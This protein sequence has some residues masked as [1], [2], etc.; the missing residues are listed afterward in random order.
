MVVG[1]LSASLGV[2]HGGKSSASLGVYHG[3]KRA[4]QPPRVIPMV[5]RGSQPPRV[6]PVS[7]LVESSH[8]VG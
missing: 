1:S 4:S 8:L 3:G 2:Y 7:L 6:I 5:E